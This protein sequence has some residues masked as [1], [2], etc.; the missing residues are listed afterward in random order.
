MLKSSI[1]IVAF[2][3]AG[4]LGVSAKLGESKAQ[5]IKRYG[6]AIDTD[7]YGMVD[8]DFKGYWISE[9]FN[10]EGICDLIYYY[11]MSGE[12]SDR[13]ADALR[14]VNYPEEAGQAWIEQEVI[15]ADTDPK[16][17]TRT[18]VTPGDSGILREPT[19]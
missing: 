19:V 7:K 13:E 17:H 2:A 1:L 18:W 9:L 14:K 12:I 10:E 16:A 3:I 4:I 8:W 5:S 6:P 11:K 15:P